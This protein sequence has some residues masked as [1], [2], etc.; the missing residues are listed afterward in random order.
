[1][2]LASY[3]KLMFKSCGSR[4]RIVL[5]AELAHDST[6]VSS[7]NFSL[8]TQDDFLESIMNEYVLGLNLEEKL[9]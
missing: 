8:S 4:A 9:A 7:W 3:L 5:H 1:M 2:Y 6:N